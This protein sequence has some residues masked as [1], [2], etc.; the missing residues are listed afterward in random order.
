M[1]NIRF[2]VN[3]IPSKNWLHNWINWDAKSVE[4]D[5]VSVK[6]IGI[7][8][9]RAHLMW[10]YFQ[11]DPAVMSVSCMEHLDEFCDICEKLELD[12][13]ITL[14]NGFVSGQFFY[15]AWMKNYTGVFGVGMFHNPDIIEAQKFYIRNIAKVVADRPH[16]IGFD[17]G[18]ELPIII[19]TDDKTVTRAQCDEWNCIMLDLCEEVAPG[20]LH[21][22]GVD[23][24][25]WIADW[26]FSREVLANT[27]AI[28][29]L[30]CYVLF[31]QALARYGRMSEESIHLAPM[32]MEIARA[33]C[34]NPERMYWIQEFGTASRQFDDEMVNFVTE[35]MHAMYTEKNVWG[36]TWW[37]S[38]NVSPQFRCYDE[39][40][41]ELGLF[42]NDNNITPAGILYKKLIEEYKSNNFRIPKRKKALIF[43]PFD[44]DGKITVDA[45]WENGHRYAECVRKGIYPA[46]VLP[47]K[48]NDAEYL[49]SRG[50]EE[51]ID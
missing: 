10:Q 27:G 5:L 32:M 16:F 29:P 17:L 11:I 33:Y 23:G 40:E 4:E 14:F 22:N 35:S 47:E 24:M 28:T 46:F 13:C 37:C 6:K 41:Y 34:D 19:D 45:T 3:Y 42:D 30:H 25:P 38:H 18:N 49:K 21:N 50:I 48:A 8:H 36:I 15:P 1:K 43:R 2:G 51:I 39:L 9:I 7:D 12:F 26:G 31:T 44:K 20:K